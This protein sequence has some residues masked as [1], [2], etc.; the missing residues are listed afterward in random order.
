MKKTLLTLLSAL[1]LVG[2]L[3]LLPLGKAGAATDPFADA[4]ASNTT[5]TQDSALCN[6]DGSTNPVSGNDGVIAKAINI[7]SF[8]TGAAS[9]I[10]IVIGG[11]KYMTAG[12]ESSK[13]ASAKSTITYALIG[14][15]IFLLSRGILAYV[16]N[17]I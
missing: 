11:I 9:M 1:L 17:R 5:K 6:T 3:G 13:V 8:L 10:M 7:F 14:I 12:G 16:I 15:V 2:V 4:C